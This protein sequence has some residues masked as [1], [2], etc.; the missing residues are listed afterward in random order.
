MRQ[1]K[2]SLGLGIGNNTFSPKALFTAGTNGVFYDISDSGSLWSDTAGTTQSTTNGIV[3][4]IDD[5]SGNNNHALQATSSLSPTK[6]VTSGRN[7]VVFDGVDDFLA[8][9]AINLAGG[10][11]ITVVLGVAKVTDASTQ[12]V[13]E[14]TT[15]GGSFKV[16]VP[17]GGSGYTGAILGSLQSD[18]TATGFAAPVNVVLSVTGKISTDTNILRINGTQVAA[19]AT[20]QG[21]GNFGN[22]PLYLG[23]RDGTSLPFTGSIYGLIIVNRVL[24][25]AELASAEAWMNSKTG[26]F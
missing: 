12:M 4:R 24:T 3:A 7:R 26:A 22:Y 1:P 6:K 9:S 20:D 5:K 13:V 10:N 21:T 23:M 16:F 2:I 15:S 25:P 11:E 19:P 14:N 17:A 8:T 18:A